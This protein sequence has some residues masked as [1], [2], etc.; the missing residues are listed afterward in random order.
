MVYINDYP[1]VTGVNN[2]HFHIIKGS[3]SLSSIAHT[4]GSDLTKAVVNKIL[5]DRHARKQREGYVI[6]ASD[7]WSHLW[8]GIN[9]LLD[10]MLSCLQEQNLNKVRYM[11]HSKDLVI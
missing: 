4:T 11:S 7:C 9:P 6:N 10:Y 2:L 5:S 1:S 3:W 8:E